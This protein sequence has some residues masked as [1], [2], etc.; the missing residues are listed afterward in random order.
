MRA[1]HYPRS[2]LT[3]W[4]CHPH[5]TGRTA[6]S[7][8]VIAGIAQDVSTDSPQFTETPAAGPGRLPLR[9][10]PGTLRRTVD[11]FLEDHMLQ[12]AAALTFFG[13]ISLFPALLAL[14]SLLGLIGAPALEP[15]IQ[16]ASQLA[17]GAARDITLDALRSIQDSGDQAGIAF[18]IGLAVALWT[19]SAYVGAFIPAANVVWEVED[20]RPLWK[21]LVIRLALTLVLLALIFITAVTV[22]LTG[23]IARE[24]G[25]IV[26][27]GETAV[28]VWQLAKWP[29]LVLVAMLLL[30]I[31]YW[32]SPNVRHPGWRWL[33][34][35]S[36][37]AVV[38]WLAASLGFTAYV[39]RFSSYDATYGS[40]GGVLVF[41]LWLWLTNI[42]IMIGA[43]LNAEL[44]RTRA[45]EAGMRPPDRT[46]FLPLRDAEG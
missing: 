31:L 42:A 36:V 33:T 46:P 45:I 12:W 17:P 19:A 11:Q 20:G 23:P 22:V 24:V 27:L 40:I 4:R 16:N 35:G 9:S 41:L 5:D 29:F 25:G 18:A 7:A 26:G 43:E 30:S 21:R 13:V 32:A 38:L 37:V 8:I 28:D 6:A 3:R 34:P 1:G 14:V 2:T 10:W 44:A 39:S 15:L